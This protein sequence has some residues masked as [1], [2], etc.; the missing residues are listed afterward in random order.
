MC[1]VEGSLHPHRSA[2]E[3]LQLSSLFDPSYT[4]GEGM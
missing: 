2:S 4:A 1:A 3:M